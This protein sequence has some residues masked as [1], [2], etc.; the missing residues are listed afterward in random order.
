MTVFL[1]VSCRVDNLQEHLGCQQ[2]VC[3]VF[4]SPLDSMDLPSGEL[5]Q[6][7]SLL[8]LNGPLEFT[9]EELSHGILRQSSKGRESPVLNL[10]I[11]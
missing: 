5:T 7:G 2:R 4:Y 3:H 6:S 1:M 9:E 11:W 10:G 8:W